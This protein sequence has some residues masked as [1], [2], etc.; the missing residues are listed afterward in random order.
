[1]SRKK[2]AI[3]LS[4]TT[5]IVIVLGVTLLILGLAFVRGLFGKATTLTEDAFRIAEQEIQSK[6]SPTDKFY[7]SGLRFEVDPG[8]AT[9]I[10]VGV[11]NIGEDMKKAT[12]TIDVVTGSQGGSASWFTLPPSQEI[13]PGERKAFPVEVTLPRGTVPGK[14]YGFTL[15]A[16]KEGKAYDSQAILVKAKEQ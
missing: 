15:R 16:V 13:A 4:M 14:S 6:M 11:Q 8:K 9:L 7:V 1:M 10:T 5:I 3:E 2:G 12:F